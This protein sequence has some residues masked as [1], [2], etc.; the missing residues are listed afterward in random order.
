M[1]ESIIENG[2]LVFITTQM[3][4]DGNCIAIQQYFRISSLE[5]WT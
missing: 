5:D 4:K 3:S 2:L 1:P